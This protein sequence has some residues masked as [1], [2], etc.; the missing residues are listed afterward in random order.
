MIKKKEYFIIIIFIF[1]SNEFKINNN[2]LF[3]NI[4]LTVHI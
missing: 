3:I 4:G 1:N 2:F